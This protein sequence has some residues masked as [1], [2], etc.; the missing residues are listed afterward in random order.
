MIP[1]FFGKKSWEIIEDTR[2]EAAGR[3]LSFLSDPGQS[4]PPRLVPTTDYKTR[5]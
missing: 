1:D 5:D 2:S 3:A 4:Q